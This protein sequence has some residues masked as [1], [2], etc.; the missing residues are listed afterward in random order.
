MKVKLLKKIRSAADF[1]FRKCENS[2]DGIWM[3]KTK[4]GRIEEH[5]E[6]IRLLET[7]MYKEYM[8]SYSRISKMISGYYV[9][10]AQRKARV[11]WNN[12]PPL[13]E[14]EYNVIICRNQL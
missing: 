1:K 12:V 14:D 4:D 6:L 3:M 8:F 11:K 5:L 10:K 13:T 7:L 9:R 2:N